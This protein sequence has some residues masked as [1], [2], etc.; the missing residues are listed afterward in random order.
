MSLEPRLLTGMRADELGNAWFPTYHAATEIMA[1]TYKVCI[2]RYWDACTVARMIGLDPPEDGVIDY[3]APPWAKTQGEVWVM[4]CVDLLLEVS[5]SDIYPG[6]IREWAT[7]EDIPTPVLRDVTKEFGDH[8]INLALNLYHGVQFRGGK[9][10]E[11]VSDYCDLEKL[12]EA[13]DEPLGFPSQ[14]LWDYIL[15]LSEHG[16][17]FPRE[18]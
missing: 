4:E 9:L 16:K 10:L 14:K 1:F 13:R 11:L 3:V 15:A 12:S 8:T 17:T 5:E 7:T 2:E 18:D 6:H